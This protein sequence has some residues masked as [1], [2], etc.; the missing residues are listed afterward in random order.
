MFKKSRVTDLKH[1]NTKKKQKNRRVLA[2]QLIKGDITVDQLGRL[3]GAASSGVLRTVN[4]LSETEGITL[5]ANLSQAVAQ[6]VTP[7]SSSSS[8]ILAR[9]VAALAATPRIP[10]PSKEIIEEKPEPLPVEPEVEIPAEPEPPVDA[11][12]TEAAGDEQQN[13]E[14]VQGAEEPVVETAPED[15]PAPAAP[16]KRPRASTKSDSEPEVK[17]APKRK[18][19]AT[20]KS[21]TPPDDEIAKAE[22]KKRTRAA[23]KAV[24]A[25]DETDKAT[26]KK[27]TRAATKPK[28]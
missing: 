8:A 19:R 1:R 12:E 18:T 5:A 9:K 24:K 10:K 6:A 14:S 17:P 13:D 21:V 11:L 15:D 20:T 22:P 27:R 2:R 3:A 25:A 26:P 7:G 4:Y 23:P 28:E 16:K